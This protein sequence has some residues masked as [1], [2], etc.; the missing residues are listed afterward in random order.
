M[1]SRQPNNLNQDDAIIGIAF[2]K[3]LLIIG[4]LSS[5]SLIF[6]VLY[7]IF[8]SEATTND[9]KEKKIEQAITLD[10]ENFKLPHIKFIEVGLKRG[11]DFIHES[12]AIGNKF[13]PETMGAGVAVFDYDLDGDQDLL[14]VNSTSLDKKILTNTYSSIYKNDG[15]AFFTKDTNSKN[16]NKNCYGQGVAIGDFDGDGRQ[17]LFFANLGPN[18]LYKNTANGFIEVIGSQVTGPDNEWSTSAG[19]LDIDL[20]GDLDL[21]V[22]NY[23][24]W[25]K[26]KDIELA[27]TLNGTDRAY[28]P[29]KQYKGTH[30][31]LF[32]NENGT[33]IDISEE[34]GIK[35]KNEATNVPVGK[36]LALLFQ[37]FDNDGYPDVLVANDTTRNFLFKN[38]K[39][40]TFTE[41]GRLSGIAFDSNGKSTGAMG[42]DAGWFRND[43]SLAIGIGN[44]ANEMTSLYVSKDD[45]LSFNDDSI[46]EGIGSQS[47]LQLSFGLLFLDYDL[48]GRVDLFQTNGHLEEEINNI[49]KSQHYRQPSQLF[50]N[51]GTNQLSC[52][53]YVPT[54]RTGDLSIPIVGRGASYGDL[55]G[56]GDL[57]L[58]VTQ[59][60]D[61]PLLF[62]NNQETENN[63][64]RVNLKSETGNN[65]YCLGAIIKISQGNNIQKRV[66]NP[67][68]SYLS[69]TELTT[70]F[71]LGKN[72]ELPVITVYIPLKKPLVYKTTS[73]NTTININV[74]NMNLE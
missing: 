13:L 74:D 61:R 69:Q 27:F 66:I 37:D 19:F 39:D 43:D 49:E 21:W 67:T 26:E 57:D 6:I 1:T 5:L 30:N 70:T 15:S 51:S 71:G 18:K 23:I 2:K 10:G 31:R 33:F 59:T 45:P 72:K 40:R 35:I 25:S 34:A 68:R 56:D 8:K 22:T 7:T 60:G 73:I 44:F 50:W 42:I 11:L 58:I 3:S 41:I 47:R 28:G 55:D 32:K 4:I 20:D 17:D 54:N 64:I 63:W 9:I 38:N 62:I 53:K 65:K 14:F 16:L 48:D 52:F 24:E 12:G 36:G 46:V 29:P